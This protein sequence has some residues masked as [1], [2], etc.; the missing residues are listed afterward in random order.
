VNRIERKGEA[1]DK[2]L[3]KLFAF[4]VK[5]DHDLKEGGGRGFIF[6]GRTSLILRNSKGLQI[7]VKKKERDGPLRLQ[8]RKKKGGSLRPLRN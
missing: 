1:I 5:K 8:E 7:T 6:N 2:I 4:S 3:E